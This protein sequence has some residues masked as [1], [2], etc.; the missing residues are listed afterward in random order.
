MARV[1]AID[2]GTKRCGIAVTDPLQIIASGLDTIPASALWSF[3]ERY[4]DQEEV[5]AIVLGLP[6]HADG[7]PTTVTSQVVG[8]ERKIKKAY[9]ELKV[10][11]QDEAYSSSDAVEAIMLSGAKKKKRRDKS[12]IDKI[13]AVIILQR[14]L[15]HI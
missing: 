6:R 7:A 11:F 5:E 12:L 13:S 8:L 15:G 1:L 3:I 2:V 10:H 14:F 9:P 4:L